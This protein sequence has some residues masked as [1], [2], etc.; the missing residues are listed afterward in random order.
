[1]KK[2]RWIFAVALTLSLCAICSGCS[3]QQSLSPAA[4]KNLTMTKA[5]IDQMVRARVGDPYAL[6]SGAVAAQIAAA[7]AAAAQKPASPTS[8][9]AQ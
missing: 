1:M 4:K 8:G 9:S 7:K 3:Q 6:N 5:Q 2:N